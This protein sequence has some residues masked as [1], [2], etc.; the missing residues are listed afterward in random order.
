M[1]KNKPRPS[2]DG[3][4]NKQLYFASTKENGALMESLL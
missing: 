1:L 3:R 2:N 4:L